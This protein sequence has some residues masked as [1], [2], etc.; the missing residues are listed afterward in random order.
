MRLINVFNRLP[1]QLKKQGNNYK[2]IQSPGGVVSGLSDY[3]R[4][5]AKKDKKADHLWIGWPGLTIPDKDRNAVLLQ[6]LDR[7][8]Y[9]VFLNEEQITM[10]YEGF[11]NNTLWPLFHSFPS[12]VR[13]NKQYWQHYRKVN[14]I[15]ASAVLDVL[16]PGDTVWIHDYQLLLVPGILRLARPDLEIGFFLHIPFPSFEIF[17]LLP[18]E[19][20]SALLEGML[21]SDLVG[22]HTNDYVRHFLRSVARLRGYHQSMSQTM[23][24]GRVVKADSFPLG[25]DVDKLQR[26]ASSATVIQER[27]KFKKILGKTKVILS[28]DRLDYT[29]GILERLQAFQKLLEDD[30]SFHGR[31]MLMLVIVPSREGVESYQELKRT[32]DEKVGSINGKFGTVEWM[33]IRYQYTSLSLYRLVALYTLSDVALVTPLRDGMNLVA[34]EYVASRVNGT[35]VLILSEMTGAAEELGEAIIVNPNHVEELTSCIRAALSMPAEEQIQ[36]NRIMQSRLREYTALRWATDFLEQLR[37]AAD[38]NRSLRPVDLD[39]SL[40]ASITA[41]FRTAHHPLLL[42]DYDGTLVPFVT[43]PEQAKPSAEL[44]GLIKSII[45][46]GEADIVII[47]GR[48][49]QF[50]E[51]WFGNLPVSLIAEHGAWIKNRN[52]KW[53]M[54]T[55]ADKGWKKSLLPVLITARDR[56]PGSF[57]EEKDH[58]LAWHYRNAP[59]D[60]A[61][62]RSRELL[63]TLQERTSNTDLEV[64]RGNKV[65][66]IHP[67][68]ATKKTATEHIL[69]RADYD[70]ILAVGDDRT[71][72]DMFRALPEHAISIHVGNSNSRARYT[73]AEP[74]DVITFLKKLLEKP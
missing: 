71:D 56:L 28:V 39:A 64:I 1:I 73:T 55:S 27:K 2:I 46:R 33:P 20:R 7:K 62:A 21:G 15:F 25:V 8:L 6:C 26:A 14:D 3:V 5:M 47:S 67:D 11:S 32:V 9:P 68:D 72:E 22:F 16:K 59:V 54:A 45:T 38:H 12:F 36:R 66:E 40:I 31:I 61:L 35:G 51:R 74:Q 17:R 48:D 41:R 70:F 42:L 19:W 34:K 63:N 24:G 4:S 43:D 10:Y 49:R 23:V 52:Q 69:S 30:S 53:V 37:I 29:K 60:L 57:I 50:L 44:L 18:D 65:I 13:Y 58:S